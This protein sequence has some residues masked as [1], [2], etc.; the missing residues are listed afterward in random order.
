MSGPLATVGNIARV[1]A[2]TGVTVPP[3]PDGKTLSLGLG[4]GPRWLTIGGRLFAN[5]ISGAMLDAFSGPQYVSA[6]G[7]IDVRGALEVVHRL[8]LTATLA[9]TRTV[10]VDT[11][12]GDVT[13]G[14]GVRYG[15][16]VSYALWM[17]S[18]YAD[19]FQEQ[20]WFSS[21]AAQGNSTRTGLTIG[22]AFQP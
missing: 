12:R 2:I 18:V 7:A 11:M 15:G 5:G 4:F 8:S 19:V 22:I 16:G 13:W 21:G 14:N 9:P 1:T 10:L 20:L 3:P 6:G 17:V